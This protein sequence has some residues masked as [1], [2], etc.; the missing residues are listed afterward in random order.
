MPTIYGRFIDIK[1]QLFDNE[2]SIKYETAL[3]KLKLLSRKKINKTNSNIK[4]LNK[5]Y[6]IFKKGSKQYKEELSNIQNEYYE[7]LKKFE[8][9]HNHYLELS[10]EASKINVYVIQKKLEQLMNANSLEDLKLTEEQATQILSG[11]RAF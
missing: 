1:T 7:E 5:R 2:S 10:R 6:G 3:K 4:A 8:Q 9:D 11:E